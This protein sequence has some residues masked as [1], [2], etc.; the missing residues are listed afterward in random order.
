MRQ[1]DASVGASG[2]ATIGHGARGARYAAAARPLRRPLPPLSSGPGAAAATAPS[3]PIPGNSP[4]GPLIPAASAPPRRPWQP[5]AT[6]GQP[7]ERP[8][9]SPPA[10]AYA[11]SAA[12]AAR[13]GA[14]LAAGRLDRFFRQAAAAAACPPRV[15]QRLV[16]LLGSAG[17]VGL[18]VAALAT[19]RLPVLPLALQKLRE[20]EPAARP[21]GTR[22]R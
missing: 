19:Q 20:T 13:P 12:A 15:L 7:R 1:L 8:L 16:E 18:N 2:M 3:P 5:A 21:A 17:L 10:D 4:R 9:E 11:G 22:S 6:P 14:A